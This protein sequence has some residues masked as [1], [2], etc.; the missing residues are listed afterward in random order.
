MSTESFYNEKASE[1]EREK[2]MGHSGSEKYPK[3]IMEHPVF[4]INQK[5]N[6]L[7]MSKRGKLKTIREKNAEELSTLR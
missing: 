3:M 2:R 4:V 6:Q 7:L 5:T 1:L